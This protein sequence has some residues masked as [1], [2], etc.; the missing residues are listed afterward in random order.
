[1]NSIDEWNNFAYGKVCEMAKTHASYLDMLA[2]ITEKEEEF[3]LEFRENLSKEDRE[4]LDSYIARCE[5]LMYILAQLA[6]Q[7]GKSV[8]SH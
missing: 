1:M 2:S 5:N 4:N 7:F 3:Y 6:Y 8:G